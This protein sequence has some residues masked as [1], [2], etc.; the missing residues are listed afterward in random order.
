MT[1]APADIKTQHTIHYK[2]PQAGGSYRD[3]MHCNGSNRKVYPAFDNAP[4]GNAS[5]FVDALKNGGAGKAAFFIIGRH[6]PGNSSVFKCNRYSAINHSQTR[7]HMTGWCR[8][9]VQNDLDPGNVLFLKLRMFIESRP[10]KKQAV[11]FSHD[12]CNYRS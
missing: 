8:Q 6:L 12:K 2:P 7:P 11:S 4:T 1:R 5:S 9:Q 3:M 10:R